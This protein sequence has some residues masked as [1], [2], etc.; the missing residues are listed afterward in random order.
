MKKRHLSNLEARI[1]GAFVAIASTLINYKIGPKLLIPLTGDEYM[2]TIYSMVFT[3]HN[4][5]V[6]FLIFMS[7]STIVYAL[8]IAFRLTESEPRNRFFR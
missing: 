7:V 1:I 2:D 3:T 4:P 5:L 8:L 6:V